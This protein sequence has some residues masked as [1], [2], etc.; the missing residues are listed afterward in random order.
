MWYLG[1]NLS[2]LKVPSNL[3][4][5]EIS[6]AQYISKVRKDKH[7][8]PESPLHYPGFVPLSLEATGYA[9]MNQVEKNG[10]TRTLHLN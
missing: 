7:F 4:S 1:L 9:D 8:T 3:V 5:G 6:P 2:G 10:K